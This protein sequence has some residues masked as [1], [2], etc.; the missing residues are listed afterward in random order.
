MDRPG[1]ENPMRWAVA[2]RSVQGIDGAPDA[3]ALG[4]SDLADGAR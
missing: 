1:A 4:S 2:S 3:A